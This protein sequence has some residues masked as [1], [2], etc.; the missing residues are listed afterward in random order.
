MAIRKQTVLR[1]EKPQAEAALRGLVGDGL[2]GQTTGHL[3]LQRSS[4]TSPSADT[5]RTS[6]P[7]ASRHP[8]QRTAPLPTPPDQAERPQQRLGPGDRLATE[9]APHRPGHSSSSPN[10]SSQYVPD[11]PELHPD[12]PPSQGMPVDRHPATTCLKTPLCPV[13]E[14]LAR[15]PTSDPAYPSAV[16]H[17]RRCRSQGPQVVQA[18]A[19]HKCLLCTVQVHAGANCAVTVT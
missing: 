12:F 18:S 4:P 15:D 17:H 2:T 13:A 3:D 10:S 5:Q 16:E 14:R 19:D 9:H 8:E 11:G 6:C 1:L 7:H